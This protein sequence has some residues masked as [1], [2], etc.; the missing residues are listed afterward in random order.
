MNLIDIIIIFSIVCSPSI[1][2]ILY[3]RYKYLKLFDTVFYKNNIVELYKAKNYLENIEQK[4][5]YTKDFLYLLIELNNKLD[6]KQKALHYMQIM[7]EM[8]FITDKFELHN[9]QIKMAAILFELNQTTEAFNK[10]FS[11][12]DT[13]IYD[14]LWC[15]LVGKIYFSQNFYEKARL[16]FFQATNIEE[17]N[18]EAKFLFY[19]VNAIISKPENVIYDFLSFSAFNKYFLSDLILSVIYF[20]KND[21]DKSYKF[22]NESIK[23]IS[24]NNNYKDFYVIFGIIISELA[25][26]YGEIGKENNL[27]IYN[28]YIQN[29]IKS[30]IT[31]FYKEKIINYILCTCYILDD[32]ESFNFYKT[33][34]LK[35][36]NNYKNFNFNEF[37]EKAK[38]FFKKLKN[39]TII[40]DLL[41]LS[42][43]KP[44]NLKL[45][46]IKEDFEIF[47][48]K[49]KN[50]E[51][52]EKLIK[53]FI[54]LSKKS[55][56]NYS[57]KICSIFNYKIKFYRYFYRTKEKE[58]GINIICTKDYPYIS[59]EIV[60]IRIFT[61]YNLDKRYLQYLYDLMNKYKAKK[62]IFICN[63]NFD[64]DF[65]NYSQNFP[66]IQI[67]DR[68]KLGYLLH[69][70]IRNK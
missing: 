16:Y 8:G 15:I 21:F 2:F 52:R 47:F 12:K 66:E 3:N 51:I 31:Q 24:E 33:F 14:P 10:L 18:F 55:F 57:L 60:C 54:K 13:G 6:N 44:L 67:M 28:I 17:N 37:E 5:P 63:F 9:Y 65:I 38:E 34:L 68:N 19:S 29:I 1:I 49:D 25:K 43:K 23:K 42:N 70:S 48:D 22:S 20:S 35:I 61:K 32:R 56:I 4:K 50:L 62:L 64:N 41:L 40:T 27:K 59:R 7:L 26:F 30:E 36:N 45:S 46:Y 53:D 69:S 39:K 58:K 11:I